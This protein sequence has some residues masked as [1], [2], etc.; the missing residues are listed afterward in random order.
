MPILYSSI[1]KSINLKAATTRPLHP[2]KHQ[3]YP[4][5]LTTI[6][7]LNQPLLNLNPRSKPSTHSTPTTATMSA[8]TEKLWYCC[9]CIKRGTYTKENQKGHAMWQGQCVY[10]SNPFHS[11][12]SGCEER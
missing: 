7:K 9:E 4:S 2:R 1:S 3:Q 11:K 8:G 6:P 12:C 10:C 5:S